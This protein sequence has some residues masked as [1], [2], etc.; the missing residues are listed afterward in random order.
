[1][2]VLLVENIHASA[3]EYFEENGFEVEALTGALSEDALIE[4]LPGVHVLGI[5]SKT[6]VT[7]RVFDAAR[8]LLTLG[9]FCIGTNQ[10]D[11]KSAKGHGV[12]V[13]NAPFSN[14]R[15][16]AEMML[17]EVIALARQLG[18]RSR[19]VH[20][21]RWR[22]ISAGCF[23]VRGKTLGIVGYGHIGSQVGVLA[24]AVGMRVIFYDIATR[25]PMGNNQPC[26]ALSDLLAKA[27]F[28]TLHVPAT[29]QT[30]DM[31]GADEIAR[32]KKGAYLLNASRGTVVQIPAL[33]SALKAG[34]L[35]GAAID[36]YPEEPETNSDGFESELRGLSNVILTPHIGGSTVEAQASIG[37]EV[38]TSLVKFI[39]AGTTTGS[40][41]FPSVEAVPIPGTHRVLNA[42]RNVPGVLRDINRIV[43]DVGGNILGQVLATD[44][45]VG[46]LVMDIEREVSEAV[47]VGMASLPTNLRTR[48]LY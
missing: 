10:V 22:K 23:E 48:V 32:M 41:N 29:P 6:L 4:K 13:F 42:H 20:A 28:V 39:D 17:A 47:S 35:A 7:P 46:Y 11:L 12:V 26:A 2:K 33:A 36:V 37:R 45:D 8:D 27:D 3:H 19:E 34:R 21:G 30:H 38:A 43:S 40:V 24:E 31:I 18:D 5:R 1:M 15:S 9:C 14:T 25:L 44:A 16:V